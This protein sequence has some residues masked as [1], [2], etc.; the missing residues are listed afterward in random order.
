M[1]LFFRI[2]DYTFWYRTYCFI[3]SVEIFRCFRYVISFSF[4]LSNQIKYSIKSFVTRYTSYI[5]YLDTSVWKKQYV[6]PFVIIG[7]IVTL[8]GIC[9][10]FFGFEICVRYKKNARRVQDP[11][12]DTMKNIHHI[13]HWMDP[14][15]FSIALKV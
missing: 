13:K 12:I 8:C 10:I 15:K 1:C 14:G 9:L 7:P 3:H 5:L 11:E 2:F 6:Y 4:E